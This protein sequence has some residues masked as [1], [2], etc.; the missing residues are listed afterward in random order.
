MMKH[1]LNIL[2][3]H[4]PSH[5]LTGLHVS[6]E[7]LKNIECMYQKDIGIDGL[8]H[9]IL[10]AVPYRFSPLLQ[11]A[12]F[13]IKYR[14]NAE[15]VENVTPLLL[16][17]VFEEITSGMVLCPVPLHWMRHME[18]G[19]NQSA[20]IAECLSNHTQLPVRHLL[21]RTRDTGHQAWRSREARLHAMNDSFS[22]RR[23]RKIPK[24]V[25]L[26]DDIVTTGATLHECAKVLQK[27]GVQRIDAW[28]I[29]RG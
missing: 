10:S 25:V 7:E 1:L 8:P 28:V 14:R 13:T 17:G 6:D 5:P 20:C 23:V 11:R 9:D 15:M 12:M 22:M 4:Q 27:A 21:R 24:H 3:P 18:R 26:V 29:A 2:Y 16:D 19:F